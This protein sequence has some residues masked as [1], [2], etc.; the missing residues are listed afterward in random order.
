[1]PVKNG[2]VFR[3]AVYIFSRGL[4]LQLNAANSLYGGI[5]I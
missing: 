5:A 4:E 3:N 2:T 1:M